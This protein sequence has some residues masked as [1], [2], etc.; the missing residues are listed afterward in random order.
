[1]DPLANASGRPGGLMAAFRYPDFRVL[2]LATVANQVGMGMQQVML[3]WLIFD[4]TGSGGMIGVVFAARAAPNL[5]VGFVAGPVADRVDRRWLLRLTS[6]LTG[7]VAALLAALLYTDNLEVWHLVLAAVLMGALLSFYI[8]ARQAYVYDV[9]GG[10]GAIYGI[11]LITVAQNVGGIVGAL[12]AGGAIQWFGPGTGFAAMAIVYGVAGFAA[13]GLRS[14]GAAAPQF[15]EP[16]WQNFV[17]YL[18]ALKTNRNLGILIGT[19]ALAEI[20]GF[21]HQVMLP[22]LTEEVL[23]VGAAGLGVLTAFRFVGGGFGVV[24]VTALW[25]VP[26]RGVLLLV[27]LVGFGL[28]QVLLSQS[29]GFVMAVVFVTFINLMATATDI[30]HHMLLQLSVPNEERGRA[31]GSWIVGLGASPVGHLEIG[32]V[33]D[34]TSPRF[35]LLVNGIALASMAV[36]LGVVVPRLRRM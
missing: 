25:R 24:V 1:M 18:R 20:V 34:A 8:T 12:L 31:M 26:R 10:D 13:Y 33:G 29:T 17:G 27:F 2:W 5:V 16:V 4:I 3:G 30:T 28:G 15:T 7:A 22:V 32:Y 23:N 6:W 11:G 14:R 35:A 19:T 21:S 36:V 9:V